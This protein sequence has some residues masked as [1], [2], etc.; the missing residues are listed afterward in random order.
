MPI[1]LSFAASSY[2]P[3]RA[4]VDEPPVTGVPSGPRVRVVPR[5]RLTPETGD[6]PTGSVA[7]RDIRSFLSNGEVAAL[8]ASESSL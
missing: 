4:G 6:S 5:R 8:F 2:G 1:I 3:A 7:L